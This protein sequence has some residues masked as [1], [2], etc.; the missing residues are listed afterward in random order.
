MD[1]TRLVQLGLMV[2]LAITLFVTWRSLSLEQMVFRTSAELAENLPP[3]WMVQVTDLHFSQFRG[4]D[5]PT[6]LNRFCSFLAHSVSPRA[7]II[8]GDLVDAKDKTGFG[9]GQYEEEWITYRQTSEECK[10]ILGHN[11]KWF[12][13]RGNHDNF[14]V[15]NGFTGKDY[16][17][18]Y[19]T[20]GARHGR[21]YLEKLPYGNSSISVVG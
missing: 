3:I 17:K 16:F 20:Q 9:S 12:D 11:V 15:D 14:D 8:S 13:L 7:V 4:P 19:S 5:R 18:E 10:R 21:S 6:A 1:H 2:S